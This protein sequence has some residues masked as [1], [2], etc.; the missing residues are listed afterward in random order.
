MPSTRPTVDPVLDI[1][2]E[3]GYDFDELDGDGYKR[4]IREAI[5]KTHPDTGGK[6]ADPEKFRILNKEFK[7]IRRGGPKPSDVEAKEKNT[8]IRGD[9]LMGREPKK[10]A[11]SPTADK[12]KLLTGSGKFNTDTVK[13]ADV[14]K[15]K[16]K[17]SSG[18]NPDK[19]DTIAKTVESIALLL[20]RQFKLEKKQQRDSKR[21]Q[22]KSDRDA[23]ED[24]LEAKPED[25]KTGGLPK[26]I[27][28]PALSFFD[29]IK[30]FFFNIVL[31]ASV[32]KIMEWLKDPANQVKI[33]QFK[34]FLIDNAPVIIGALAGLALLPVISSL[35]GMVGGIM[36]GLSMLGL[37]VPLLP[38]I[39]KGILI[40]AVAALAIAA[41]NWFSKKIV[42]GKDF[43]RA[44]D[45]NKKRLEKQG[46]NAKGHV[47]DDDGA[48]I[49]ANVFGE[50]SIT[51]REW[52][53]ADSMT[54]GKGQ[55]VKLDLIDGN[56]DLGLTPEQ[57]QEWYAANYGQESLDAKLAAHAKYT[58]TLEA[59]KAKKSEMDQTLDPMHRLKR[60]SPV[61]AV[62][63][64]PDGT[65]RDAYK[66][67]GLPRTPGGRWKM[68]TNNFSEYME[69]SA[70]FRDY[71]NETTKL[72]GLEIKKLEQQYN[73]EAMQI[74]NESKD[75]NVNIDKTI[76]TD[77]N[78]I[79]A[80]TKKGTVTIIDGGNGTSGG[81]TSGGSGDGDGEV[82]DNFSSED[83]QDLSI[84]ATKATYNLG[85]A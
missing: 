17:D 36:G 83:L 18:L 63:T 21:Q 59:I 51:G 40:A 70:A 66:G 61:S 69:K 56:P 74:F 11:P 57:H 30:K 81:N 34:D 4:S 53:E 48:T 58:T 25:K 19:L 50:N 78:N 41:V 23:R 54:A 3:L 7:K 29:K 79:S 82:D 20:R 37:A 10:D 71:Q 73:K 80:S 22:S 39:L 60:A 46:I 31:G 55:R 75:S 49:Y 42:G 12:P 35:V 13:P 43:S 84:V 8:K 16:K 5:F 62:V 9:K 72:L 65:V 24:K 77:T 33:A 85:V 45:L 28:K 26:A 44:R 15:D 27:T 76:K 2:E 14:D 1:L 64:M 68:M 52:T 32:I 38:I 67:S 6:T 47:V